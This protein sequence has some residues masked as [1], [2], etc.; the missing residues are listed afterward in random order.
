V[1]VARPVASAGRH[2]SVGPPYECPA[3]ISLRPRL[4]VRMGQ[5]S[6]VVVTDWRGAPPGHVSKRCGPPLPLM[7]VDVDRATVRIS[8][9]V[10]GVPSHVLS[11]VSHSL[12]QLSHSLGVS[13]SRSMGRDGQGLI[14]RLICLGV[15][16][17]RLLDDGAKLCHHSPLE[18][19]CRCQ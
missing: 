16:S 19:V 2:G 11:P 8:F 4:G 14:C 3:A 12:I 9:N 6:R 1:T 10:Y 15:A 18:G 17:G 7:V 13:E 5:V